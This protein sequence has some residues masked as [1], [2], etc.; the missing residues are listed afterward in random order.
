MSEQNHDVT[1]LELDR[2]SVFVTVLAIYSKKRR[3]DLLDISLIQSQQYARCTAHSFEYSSDLTIAVTM[4][5][6][7]TR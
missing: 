2:V 7:E 6:L 5:M 4:P 1:V 3:E